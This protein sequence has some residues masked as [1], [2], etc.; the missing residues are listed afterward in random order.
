MR[1]KEAPK[2][3]EHSLPKTSMIG[4]WY[5]PP[6]VCDELINLFINPD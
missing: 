6:V 5:I 1:F 2:F 3:K 4:G